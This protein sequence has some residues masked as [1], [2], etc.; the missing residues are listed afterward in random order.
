MSKELLDVENKILYGDRKETFK[1][2]LLDL[3]QKSSLDKSIAVSLLDNKNIYD[4]YCNVFTHKSVNSKDNY[5]FFEM[6]GDVTCNKIIVW[7]LKDKFPFLCNCD[8]VKVLARLRINLVSKTTFSRWASSLHF[9]KYISWD[10]ETKLKQEASV[11][12]DVFEAFVGC[13]EMIVDTYIRG[14]AG[15]YCC[16]KFMKILL[17][18][19]K[20]ELSYKKLYDPI[21]RL[22]ETFDFYN[23]N[24]QKS[25]CP[26]IYGNISF[27][28]E[29]LDTCLYHV[30]LLQS[31]GD[32]KH[33]LL[34]ENGKSIID[35][36]YSLC[37]KYLNFLEENGFKKQELK[38]YDD[39]ENM[40][41]KLENE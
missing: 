20:I 1:I 23:S 19:E 37:Q 18:K 4:L 13:T 40:R 21:T 16:S 29:K 3:L 11:L 32:K 9:D 6:I 15:T 28:H 27:S 41:L 33:I 24:T 25:T 38:Y 22:K 36:K 34:H 12:E 14:Y 7:Y 39:I 10:M 35:V 26:Y 31:S 8:G 5:E 30:K 17:D 2:F